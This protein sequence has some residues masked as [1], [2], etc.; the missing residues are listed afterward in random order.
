MVNALLLPDPALLALVR[1]EVDASTKSIVFATDT[2][3][4]PN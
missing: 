2:G 3:G 1:I 4:L